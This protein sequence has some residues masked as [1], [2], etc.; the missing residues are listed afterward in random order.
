[1][2]NKNTQQGQ[3]LVMLLVFMV[4]GIVMTTMAVALLIVNATSASN[5]EQG[6]M[7]LKI[8]ESGADNALLRILRNPLFKQTEV[9]LKLA[10]GLG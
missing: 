6:D 5:V 2:D 3:A 8:A 4:V 7:A 10:T 1:M 9:L